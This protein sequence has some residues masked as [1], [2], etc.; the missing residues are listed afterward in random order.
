MK[1]LIF[2]GLSQPS[3]T[4]KKCV[5]LF[6]MSGRTYCRDPFP[7]ERGYLGGILSLQCK[8]MSSNYQT[9]LNHK[10]SNNIL[11]DILLSVVPAGRP[12]SEK[13]GSCSLQYDNWRL[14]SRV[15]GHAVLL[16]G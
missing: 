7:L 1:G 6:L 10:D 5:L 15:F 9:L 2:L 14:R 12:H 13:M 11:F 4:V 3:L 16:K 8:I